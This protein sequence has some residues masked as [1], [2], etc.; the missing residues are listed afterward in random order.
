LTTLHLAKK[1][2]VSKEDML[3][4]KGMRLLSMSD[5]VHPGDSVVIVAK[6]DFEG[7]TAT[8]ANNQSDCAFDEV[9]LDIGYDSQVF[10]I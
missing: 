4:E 10:T 9:N 6:G 5:I 7:E 1:V 2:V 3:A 8:V